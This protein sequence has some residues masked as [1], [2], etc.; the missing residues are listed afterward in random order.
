MKNKQ[1]GFIGITIIILIALAAIGGGA[2]VYHENR[3]A[4]NANFENNIK[5]GIE[6]ASSTGATTT[7]TV[8]VTSK[9]KTPITAEVSVKTDSQGNKVPSIVVNEDQL[10]KGVAE[11]YAGNS[12]AVNKLI[13]ARAQATFSSFVIEASMKQSTNGSYKNVCADAKSFIEADIQKNMMDGDPLGVSLKSFNTAQIVCKAD[14]DNFIITMPIT[15]EDGSAAK[16]CSSASALG[17][18]GDANY[19]TYTCIK[20]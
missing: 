2:Y 15:L 17:F 10:N 11:K 9:I 6:T 12:A 18:V 1:R 14:A 20:K 3:V 19:E 4:E 13:K 5:E 8:G 7:V 16:V